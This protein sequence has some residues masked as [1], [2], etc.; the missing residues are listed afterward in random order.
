M[1]IFIPALDW[2]E[3]RHQNRFLGIF[4]KQLLTPVGVTWRGN[5][6]RRSEK[7]EKSKP[8]YIFLKK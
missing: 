1:P 7:G 2:P 3:T 8:R 4:P 6:E 5:M